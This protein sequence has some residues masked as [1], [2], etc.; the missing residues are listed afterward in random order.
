LSD[1]SR[2]SLERFASGAPESYEAADHRRPDDGVPLSELR[3]AV[4]RPRSHELLRVVE[5]KSHPP[6]QIM[7]RRRPGR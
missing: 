4:E 7:V 3:Q 1:V 5:V 6:N 2:A